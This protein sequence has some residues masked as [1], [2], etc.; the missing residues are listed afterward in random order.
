MIGRAQSRP[1]NFTILA[2]TAQISS[3]TLNEANGP[4]IPLTISPNPYPV[5]FNRLTTDSLLFGA[6]AVPSGVQFNS[7]SI[8]LQSFQVTIS[9][10]TGGTIAGAV[11]GPCLAGSICVFNPGPATVD[12]FATEV[13]PITFA[14][15]T[16]KNA[17]FN[18]FPES[19]ITV[20]SS[21]LTLA[22][23]KGVPITAIPA[24]RLGAAA[25]TIETIEDFTGKVTA[26]TGS[27]V[28]IT[29]G[30]GVALT[31]KFG[32]STTLDDPQTL[33]SQGTITACVV[34]G[35][36]VSMDGTVATDG[37]L[38]ATEFDLLNSPP[39][40]S[41]DAIE[42][43]V[44]PS[45]PGNFGLVVTDKQFSGNNTTVKDANIGDVFT[46]TLANTASFAVDTK[47]LTTATAPVVPTNL[48]AGVGDILN[49]QTVRL[50]VTAAT[51]S[52]GT[53]DQALTA[54]RVQ[55]RW[56]RFTSFVNVAPSGSTLSV[57]SIGSI[58]QL[59]PQGT[60]IIQLYSPGTTLDNLSSINMIP[61]QASNL[62][63]T[64]ALFLRS[65]PNFFA[66]KIRDQ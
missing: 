26:T 42:G 37:S 50:H 66:T 38:T 10:E 61:A 46:V 4:S 47:N 27:T 21:G 19:I 29:N 24:P 43:T 55:L 45:S 15:G 30:S 56:T 64:R 14:P 63:S 5:D 58:F 17:F 6:F 40:T 22:F 57:G 48:F 13:F 31:A 12:T 35:A 41:L 23:N 11:N 20:A 2:F 33:C 54:D 49:G 60:A 3:L 9:N 36:I 65:S 18:I 34:T 1:G 62:I 8:A 25:G 53:N 51:G 59:T 44:V 7:V 52:A 39:T 28:S 16:T 32:S